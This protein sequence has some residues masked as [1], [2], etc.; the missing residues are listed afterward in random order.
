MKDEILKMEKSFFKLKY[1]K[2][3]EWLNKAIHDDFL[4]CGKSGYLFN[5]KDTIEAL[6]SCEEDRDIEI[7]N[8][9]IQY[10][11][12]NTYLVHYFTISEGFLFY[13]TSIWKMEGFLSLYYHQASRFN[14]SVKLIKS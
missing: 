1:I 11:D 4:E 12:E 7:Y 6:L 8:F 10:M 3:K 2:D 9:E 13:R 5:K 14:Q